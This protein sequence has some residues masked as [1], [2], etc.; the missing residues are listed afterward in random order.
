[1]FE[2]G[3]EWNLA[4]GFVCQCL[5]CCATQ[6]VKTESENNNITFDVKKPLPELKFKKI[7]DQI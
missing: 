3:M 4:L 1:M 2:P 5:P 7:K 6:I